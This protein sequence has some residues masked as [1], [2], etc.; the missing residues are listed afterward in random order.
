V[1]KTIV[2][3]TLVLVISVTTTAPAAS[4]T[5]ERAAAERFARLALQC[6]HQEYPNKIAHVLAGDADARAPRE[7]YPAFHGCYDWHSSVH[8]HWLLVRLV[9]QF[10]D[11]AFAREARAALDRSLTPQ[12]LLAET[13]Y[14]QKPGRASFERPYGLAW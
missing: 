1:R 10:P 4:P 14:L 9:R 13:A 5:L 8:G 2:S 6:V 7:L 12:N 3:M 11:A